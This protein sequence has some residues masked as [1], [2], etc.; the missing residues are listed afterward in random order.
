MSH[1][2]G[3]PPAEQATRDEQAPD[4]AALPESNTTEERSE[5][6]GKFTEP[7][8]ASYRESR[9]EADS[10]SLVTIDERPARTSSA[11]AIAASIVVVVVAATGGAIPSV[12]AITGL[13]LVGLAGVTAYR[14]AL[15]A[16]SVLLFLAVIFG[17]IGGLSPL[18]ILIG[19][20]ATV[21]AWDVADH[22]LDLGRRVGRN[23]R[24]RTNEFV[25]AG[26]SLAIAGLAAGFGFGV[27]IVISGGQPVT[28][29]V[30]LLLGVVLLASALS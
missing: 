3:P 30:F 13:G 20:G 4:D 10:D 26:G 12:V 15:T 8:G 7:L 16:G 25:H 6:V 11:F 1:S 14:T 17:G 22:G 21:F 29:L 9:T 24:T 19:I 28:A 27:S 23:A 18:A 2:N 5:G